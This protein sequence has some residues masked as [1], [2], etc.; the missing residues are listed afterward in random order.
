M[1]ERYAEVAADGVKELRHVLEIIADAGNAP[2]VFHC[3]AG[4]DRTGIVAALVLT[5]LGVSEEDIVADFALTGLATERLVSHWHRD[6]PGRTLNWPGYGPAPAQL[7]RL[8]LD[9]LAARYGSVRGYVIS[10]LGVGED[11]ISAMRSG[12]LAA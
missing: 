11:T 10:G 3:A 7:M 4:K 5:L 1:A 8:F 6:Y 2:V 9:G 12:L